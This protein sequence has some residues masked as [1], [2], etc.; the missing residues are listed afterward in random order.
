MAELDQDRVDMWL[1]Y[2]EEGLRQ[3]R[4]ALEA[5]GYLPKPENPSTAQETANAE[6]TGL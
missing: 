5:S 2:V 1:G 6:K 4:Y 3:L